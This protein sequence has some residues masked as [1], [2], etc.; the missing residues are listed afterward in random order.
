LSSGSPSKRKD[1]PLENKIS[2]IHPCT[3]LYLYIGLLNWGTLLRAR[4]SPANRCVLLPLSSS[5]LP[6]DA[7]AADGHLRLRRPPPQPSLTE[8]ATVAP[9]S[10]VAGDWPTGCSA[11]AWPVALPRRRALRRPNRR[12]RRAA[13]TPGPLLYGRRPWKPASR[14]QPRQPENL[15]AAASRHHPGRRRPRRCPLRPPPTFPDRPLPQTLTRRRWWRAATGSDARAV[16]EFRVVAAR[17][18]WLSGRDLPSSSDACS[19]PPCYCNT[20]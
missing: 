3:G 10:P 18:P 11:P 2:K 17:P 4:A 19:A 5:L 13:A 1:Y 12:H 7:P 6:P 14:P 8:H 9:S 15:K 20:E 16:K